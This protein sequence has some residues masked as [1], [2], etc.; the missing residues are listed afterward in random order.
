MAYL[1]IGSPAI[2]ALWEDLIEFLHDGNRHNEVI[3][4]FAAR[5]SLRMRSGVLEAFRG[6]C[7]EGCGRPVEETYGVYRDGLRKF[8]E[9][10]TLLVYFSDFVNHNRLYSRCYAD[11][12]AMSRPSETVRDFL[13][14]ME[15]L[16]YGK[17]GAA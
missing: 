12:K 6:K 3:D 7:G 13:R 1:Q 4:L 10:P 17:S 2:I 11:L 9:D 15:A 14:Q 16:G 5:P 8:P